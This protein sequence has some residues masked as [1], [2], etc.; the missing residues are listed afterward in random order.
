MHW[1]PFNRTYFLWELICLTIGPAFMAAAI[2]LCLG[3]IVVIYGE[4]ISRIK[5]RSYMLFF[6]E[7]DVFSLVVQSVGGGIASSFPLT[8]QA[9]VSTFPSYAG[10]MTDDLID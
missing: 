1:D 8:N 4:E 7:C 5:P 10:A 9:M 3:R 6:V 2:Y